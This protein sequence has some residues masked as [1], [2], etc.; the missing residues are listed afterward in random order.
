MAGT[1]GVNFQ[2][3]FLGGASGIGASC[4]LIE[5][6]GK[7]FLVDCGLRFSP[8]NPLPDLDQL[9]GKRLD[10]ILIT[11]AH[12]D[13]TGA[14]PVVHAAFPSAPIYM[15]KPTMDLVTILQRDALRL[16]DQSERECEIP[17]YTE[18]QVDSML[19]SVVPVRHGQRFPIDST[20]VSFLPAGHILGASMIHLETKAGSILFTGDFSVAGQMTVSDLKRPGLRS[21]CIVTEAT[22][23]ARMHSDRKLAEKR[24]VNQIGEVIA[25]G[26]KVLIPAFAIGRAQEVILIIKNAMRHRQLPKIPVYVDGMVRAV[27]NSYRD[28]SAYVSNRLLREI[29][30]NPHPFYT[31]MISPVR[32]HSDREGIVN[33]ESCVIISSSGM[34]QGGPSAFYASRLA[35]DEKNAILIT[36]YQDEESP[37]RMLQNLATSNERQIHLAG[38]DIPVNCRCETYTLSAH[39]D[40]MQITGF[41]E[42]LQPRT[43]ILVHGDDEARLNLSKSLTARDIVL[44]EEG[45]PIIRSYPHRKQPMTFRQSEPILTLNAA[46]ALIGP[47]SGQ[48]LMVDSISDSWFGRTT[49][50]EEQETLLRQ[51]LDFG[52]VKRD[53]ENP[54]QVWP[55]T[56]PGR[57]AQPNPEELALEE[58]L[59]ILNPN[60]RLLEFCS[61]RKIRKPKQYA[62][63]HQ[64]RYAFEYQIILN[65]EIVS[66][67]P[68]FAYSETM[69]KQLAAQCLLEK[70]IKIL[71]PE[72]YISLSDEQELQLKLENPKGQLLEFCCAHVLRKPKIKSDAVPNGFIGSA[73]LAVSDTVYLESGIYFASNSKS[74]DHAASREL[75]NKIRQYLDNLETSLD[76]NSG[77]P[78]VSRSSKHDYID[79]RV[80][81]NQMKQQQELL[82][83]GYELLDRKGSPHQ[84][85]FTMRGWFEIQDTPRQYVDPITAG[86]KK[87][88]QKRCAELIYQAVRYD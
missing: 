30:R 74:V 77:D 42:S 38:R 26:G 78:Q 58:E 25:G 15:T 61:R 75:L 76:L 86:S 10:A 84:P 66:S 63:I 54:A 87:E 1:P 70:I 17:L 52:L 51:L 45:E 71:L 12:S 57:G 65:D 24:L 39:A 23:G 4:A 21:D 9:T 68:Q 50:T 83:F 79:S 88:C 5:V 67:E 29:A 31:D 56:K 40:R 36:G 85:I 43:V 32:Q 49:S 64:N 69:A 33:S 44:P 53:S 34:L 72:T 14:L 80:K 27:C 60:N 20:I 3:T 6:N 2:L 37:G 47:S 28:Q 16:M 7:A 22:Y 62:T 59:K 35:Q 46:S 18:K 82:D 19:N 8:I 11:H 13:H 73:C 48:P 55:L 41:I 81:L